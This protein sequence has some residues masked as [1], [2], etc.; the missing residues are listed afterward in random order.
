MSGLVV[1]VLYGSKLAPTSLGSLGMFHAFSVLLKVTLC[2]FHGVV[3]ITHIE[4]W[5]WGGGCHSL[6]NGSTDEGLVGDLCGL[7]E[8]VWELLYGQRSKHFSD[9]YF[10]GMF[11]VS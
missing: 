1:V 7:L 3:V 11:N 4:V 6:G 8:Y 5:V 10:F 9:Y 2:L